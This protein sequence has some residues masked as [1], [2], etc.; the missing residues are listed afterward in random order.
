MLSSRRKIL[1][2]CSRRADAFIAKLTSGN[3]FFLHG[4][5]ATANPPVLFLDGSAPTGSTAK[6]KDSTS[7]NFAGGNTWKD[8]GSWAVSS[9]SLASGSLTAL[10][11]LNVWLSL[12]NSDDQGTN[13]D[14]RAEVSKNGAL[15]ASGLTRCITGVTRN[16]SL[17]KEVTVV[18]GAF[19]A[20]SFNGTSDVL[21]L[22]LSTRIGTNP[23]DTKCA[24][25]NNAV[26]LRVYFDA[27]NREAEFDA[28]F[29]TTP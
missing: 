7:I 26:G 6:Y 13:F 10:S 9:P 22:K 29:E 11:N 19:S 23:N 18:F 1:D 2:R 21:S 16:P 3:D 20:V 8:V 24:G 27:T 17:A 25:H 14:L 5:G 15:V 4:S 28:I 12:Q